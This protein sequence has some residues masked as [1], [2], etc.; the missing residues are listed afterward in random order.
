MDAWAAIVGAVIGLLGGVFGPIIV[1]TGQARRDVARA[2]IE[3]RRESDRIARDASEAR[4][5]ALTPAITELL[6][7]FLEQ[8]S[9]GTVASD[10]ERADM[11]KRS[12][13][14]ALALGLLL[15]NHD[16]AIVPMINAVTARVSSGGPDAIRAVSALS[17]I[18]PAWKRGQLTAWEALDQFRKDTGESVPVDDEADYRSRS[19]ASTSQP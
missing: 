4:A 17:S 3:D 11:M 13:L 16:Q 8:V 2:A 9:M 18:L 14:A 7:S 15:E 5:R 6:T 1:N 12:M 10:T 19:E